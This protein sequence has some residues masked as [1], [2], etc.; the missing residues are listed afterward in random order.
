MKDEWQ[1]RYGREPAVPIRAPTCREAGVI[2]EM[3]GTVGF[4]IPCCVAELCNGSTYDS[5]SYCLGSNP[6]SAAKI[7]RPSFDGLFILFVLV[8]FE[9]ATRLRGKLLR[10]SDFSGRAAP[11]RDCDVWNTSRPLAKRRILVP[12]PRKKHLFMRCFFSCL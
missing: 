1:A 5:D 12:Q 4:Q 11:Q 9:A 6:S 3:N 2:T 10:W 8:G 7:E